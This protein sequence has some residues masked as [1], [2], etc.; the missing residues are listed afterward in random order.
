MTSYINIVFQQDDDA[1]E[2]L[3]IYSN[4][5]VKAAV[6]HL[7]QWDYGDNYEPARSELGNGA[8]DRLYECGPYILTVSSEFLYIGL[9]LIVKGVES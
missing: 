5:G 2:A 8:T 9:D 7:A 1:T 6:A 3:V 4:E